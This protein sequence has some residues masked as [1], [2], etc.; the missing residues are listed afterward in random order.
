MGNHDPGARRMWG[1]QQ[2]GQ[3]RVERLVDPVAQNGAGR[4]LRK[5]DGGLRTSYFEGDTVAPD[6]EDPGGDHRA[7]KAGVAHAFPDCA[8][9]FHSGCR[10]ASV[11]TRASANASWK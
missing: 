3:L 11:F 10:G 4:G 8:A 2:R 9:H 1:V 6:P 5:R 7:H